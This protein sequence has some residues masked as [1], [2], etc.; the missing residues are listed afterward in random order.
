MK[1]FKLR[2]DQRKQDWYTIEK[3]PKQGWHEKVP[4]KKTR[5]Q[6]VKNGQRDRE[7]RILFRD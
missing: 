3:L 4:N 5:P 6:V 1:N 2:M 7:M